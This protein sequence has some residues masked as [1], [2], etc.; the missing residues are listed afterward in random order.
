L[1]DIVSAVPRM[2]PL[3]ERMTLIQAIRAAHFPHR[4]LTSLIIRCPLPFRP[5]S[6]GAV[7]RTQREP[8]LSFFRAPP[9]EGP[10]QRVTL[11]IFTLSTAF[12]AGLST[13]EACPRT[14][15][16]WSPDT[17]LPRQRLPPEFSYPANRSPGPRTELPLPLGV[18]YPACHAQGRLPI[19]KNVARA[20]TVAR[21]LTCGNKSASS[22]GLL[23][24]R[25]RTRSISAACLSVE[26]LGVEP[27][28]GRLT[29]NR[30][31]SRF[32]LSQWK[33]LSNAVDAGCSGTS[34]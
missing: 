32:P 1:G 9:S 2:S 22:G 19:F 15:R 7:T 33:I 20:N 10:I 30:G 12:S 23:F 24:L 13:Q 4:A 5:S 28:S 8:P 34:P 6:V 11:K 25:G 3:V 29:C 27:A 26:G 31:H 17:L 21:Y 16:T 14:P 18:R